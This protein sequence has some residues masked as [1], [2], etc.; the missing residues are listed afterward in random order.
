MTFALNSNDL[1][2]LIGLALVCR[3]AFLIVKGTGPR[4]TP[5]KGISLYHACKFVT[6][7]YGFMQSALERAPL[8]Q[9]WFAGKRVI[10]M[11]GDSGRRFFFSQ[12]VTKVHS[13]CWCTFL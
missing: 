11:S 3:V 12:K 1:A 7:R 9:F 13:F 5:L 10:G 6:A 2:I 4:I 8:F